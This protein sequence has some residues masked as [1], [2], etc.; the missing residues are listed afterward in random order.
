[1]RVKSHWYPCPGNP[2]P[3][4]KTPVPPAAQYWLID[5]WKHDLWCPANARCIPQHRCIFPS[6]R[7]QILLM[8][9]A[10]ANTKVPLNTLVKPQEQLLSR[11]YKHKSTDYNRSK[12]SFI[13]LIFGCLFTHLH[14]LLSWEQDNLSSF[15]NPSITGL[16]AFQ[17]TNAINIRWSWMHPP[18]KNEHSP[19]DLLDCTNL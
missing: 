2:G 7:G 11:L 10:A 9:G 13:K 18:L 17:Q 1:M 8:R 15:T 4:V 6:K 14:T 5:T 12:I 19:F 3:G 16:T